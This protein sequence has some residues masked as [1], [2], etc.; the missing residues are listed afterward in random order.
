M[1]KLLE[2]QNLRVSFHSYAGEVEAVR[3]VSFDVTEG[4]A[5]AIVGE[6]GCGKSV[7]ARTIM[8]LTECPPGEIKEGSHIFFSGSDITNFSEKEWEQYR[9]QSCAIVFQDALAALNPTI[10]I[11]H[12]IEE[13]LRIHG[14]KNHNEA[15]KETLRLLEIVGIPNPEKRYRQYPH[16]FSGGMR[17]RAMIAIALACGPKLLIADEPTTALDVTIQ[18]DIL[19]LL[20]EL[21]KKTNMAIIMITHDL[22]IVAGLAERIVVMYAGKAV[23]S[24]SS[25][26]IFYEGKHPYTKA[27]L[28]S[29]P[30]LDLNTDQKLSFIE[31]APPSMIHPPKGCA[32]ANRCPYCMEICRQQEPP[33]FEFEKKHLASCWLYHEYAAKNGFCPEA[34]GFDKKSSDSENLTETAKGGIIHGCE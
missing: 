2:V 31:G 29:V 7:T 26:D 17:Q 34:D 27:L 3:G 13:K 18:A 1:E 4:E 21:Q 12:Q 16:E 22:G 8:G 9:G 6:S 32:F 10:T 25:Y 28:R 30:R 15:Y 11:G 14:M 20:K 5:V 23:E 33:C 19:E 24:G